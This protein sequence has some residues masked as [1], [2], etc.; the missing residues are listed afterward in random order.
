[1][2]TSKIFQISIYLLSGLLFGLKVQAQ[3]IYQPEAERSTL[4]ITFTPPFATEP[5]TTMAHVVNGKVV[6]Q[7]DIVLGKVEDFQ[8]GRGLAVIKDKRSRWPNGVI[9]Y[10]IV[11]DHSLKDMI[12]EAIAE[13]NEKT[14]ITLI[15]RTDETDYVEVLEDDD[16]CYSM[17]LG[18]QGGK[19]IVNMCGSCDGGGTCGSKG[20]IIHEFLHAAGFFHEHVR[21][22]RGEHV[23]INWENIRPDWRSQF[24]KYD[25]GEGVAFGPYDHGSVMHYRGFSSSRVARNKEKPVI[26]AKDKSKQKLMGQR[27]GLSKLDIR[28][29]NRIYRKKKRTKVTIER[30][31]TVE[32]AAITADAKYESLSNSITKIQYEVELVPQS[33]SMSCWAAGAAMLVGWRDQV[34]IN[35]EEIAKGIGY[36]AQYVSPNGG[37]PPDDTTM[38]AA[39]GLTPEYPMSYTVEGFADLLASYGP[40]WVASAEP[41]PHI[42]VITG[43]EGDGTPEKTI[44]TIYDPWQKGMRRFRMPN[45]GSVYKESY[46]TFM[47]KQERL[48]RQEAGIKGALYIAHN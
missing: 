3:E 2:K 18:R 42:R 24:K 12:E 31:D 25:Y 23:R 21:R 10:T 9:P 15:P 44:L 45:V 38:F 41:G 32:V 7:G 34:C 16:G 19:Q 46:A 48:A 22:D 26:I 13:I 28:Q 17:G 1:M 33:T 43:I 47:Q 14:N 5:I 20:I 39:W 27:K 29:I 4:E 30:P 36:W 11:D 6:I 40:L 8:T 35:P 37:L